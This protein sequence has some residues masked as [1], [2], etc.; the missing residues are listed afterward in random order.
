[1]HNWGEHERSLSI[2]NQYLK[3][4]IKNTYHVLNPIITIPRILHN[5]IELMNNIIQF[6]EPRTDQPLL[7]TL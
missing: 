5:S 4:Q 3:K 7:L 6:Q 1:M 2:K